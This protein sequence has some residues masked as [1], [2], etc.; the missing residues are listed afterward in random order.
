MQRQSLQRI[1]DYWGTRATELDLSFS[2]LDTIFDL[3]FCEVLWSLGRFCDMYA[4]LEV[5]LT[6]FDKAMQPEILCLC[7][8][9]VNELGALTHQSGDRTSV[10]QEER[11]GRARHLLKTCK[12]ISKTDR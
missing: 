9:A 12:P 4:R 10:G 2:S 1:L 3:T 8:E 7:A 6:R 11:F 5:G